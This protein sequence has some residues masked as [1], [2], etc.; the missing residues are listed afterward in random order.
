M[1]VLLLF[2][3]QLRC[4]TRVMS[5]GASHYNIHTTNNTNPVADKHCR[6]R[7]RSSITRSS[8]TRSSN[9]HANSHFTY[10]ILS[11]EHIHRDVHRDATSRRSCCLSWRICLSNCRVTDIQPAS[12]HLI[13]P[14]L[15][16]THDIHQFA[17]FPG[18]CC[19]L[20][21]L[22]PVQPLQPSSRV[23]AVSNEF[24]LS[25]HHERLSYRLYS[26]A[27]YNR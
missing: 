17:C 24:R 25:F 15:D 11:A 1:D 3:V 20:L 5:H 6:T 4:F 18:P 10:P 27:T 21:L 12:A 2:L 22:L 26:F 13:H 16:R 19:A 9:S 14:T 8:I 7:A 23:D